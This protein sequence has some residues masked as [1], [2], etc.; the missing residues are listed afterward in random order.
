V[1]ELTGLWKNELKQYYEI[2]GHDFK[3]LVTYLRRNGCERTEPTIRNWLQD[4]DIIGPEDDAD[5]RSIALMAQ[6]SKLLNNI[7][8]VRE[9]IKQMTSW[10]FKAS[11]IVRDK[12]KN[13]LTG[14]ANN[15]VINSQFEI[16]PLGSVDILK[17]IGKN[18]TLQDVDKRV[19]NRLLRREFV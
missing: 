18:N 15:T 9:A 12:I 5:L 19:I 6:S 3:R 1:K 8:T 11:N 16:Q 2:I 7:A 4:D 14:I 17:V 10:R 13:K